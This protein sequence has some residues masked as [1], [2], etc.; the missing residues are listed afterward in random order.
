MRL[1]AVAGAQQ[2]PAPGCD[3]LSHP[4]AKPRRDQRNH[5]DG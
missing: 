3:K 2:Q 1:D 5:R 4:T